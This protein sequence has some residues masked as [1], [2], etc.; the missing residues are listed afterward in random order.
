MS[1]QGAALLA[2]VTAHPLDDAVR[3]VYADWLEDDSQPERAEAIRL[4]V[5]RRSLDDLDPLAWLID[6]RARQLQQRHREEWQAGLPKLKEVHFFLGSE[7]FVDRVG[8][9][10][11]ESLLQHE[12]TI[13]GAAPIT[14]LDFHVAD[15]AAMTILAG[16]RHLDRLRTLGIAGV[17]S[18]A[19]F[20]LLPLAQCPG[21]AGL[22]H[23]DLNSC[24]LE[25]E[26]L[27]TLPA[28]PPW[29][30]LESLN[31]YRNC[32]GLPGL[33]ALAAAPLLSTLRSLDLQQ[34]VGS[35]EGFEELARSPHLGHLRRLDVTACG[36][37]TR[38]LG[39]LTERDW[40]CLEVLNL[41][42]NNLDPGGLR[43]L[44]NAPGLARLRELNLG[45]T[46]G[47]ADEGAEALAEGTQLSGLR[48]LLFGSCCIGQ[49]GLTAL[50]QAPWLGN[51]TRL[52]LADQE[53]KRHGVDVLVNAPLDNLRWLC[54]FYSDLD[55]TA[56]R[57]LLTAPWIARLTHLEL[58]N[59][60]IGADGARALAES[61]DL[62]NLVSLDVQ[63]NQIPPGA[64]DAL[65]LRFGDR[66]VV[67]RPGE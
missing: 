63:R 14:R 29:P 3:L 31:L 4:G 6:S 44:V 61:P 25:D 57:R 18:P 11:P 43:A 19:T 67:K 24:I 9:Y 49:W 39:V 48:S 36:L 30:G 34:A 37:P 26:F 47:L 50:G 13:F 1:N 27:L 46:P 32:F 35:R 53:V 12:E 65:R 58:Q 51:L 5:Q 2:E 17:G 41:S 21:L 10:E 42:T 38:S 60:K 66:V 45:G 55:D 52:E 59:N 23:L 40:P 56:V 54:L 62:D 22:R 16:C 15:S 20:D 28:C 64:A 33:R 7:G 8:V